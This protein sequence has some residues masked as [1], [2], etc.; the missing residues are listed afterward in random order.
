MKIGYARISKSDGSQSHSYTLLK[1][2]ISKRNKFCALYKSLLS[3][4]GKGIKF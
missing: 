1:I 2:K 3:Y 4:I